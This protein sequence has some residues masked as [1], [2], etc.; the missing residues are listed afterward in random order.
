MKQEKQEKNKTKKRYKR[1]LIL[2]LYFGWELVLRKVSNLKQHIVG[3]FKEYWQYISVVF[4]LI[5]IVS[6]GLIINK[7]YTAFG[8]TYGWVQSTWSGGA[9]TI[10]VATHTDNQSNWTKYYSADDNISTSS[11]Q[12]TL[13]S[14]S[15][16]VEDTE[17]T[18]FDGGTWN[19]DTNSAS[20]I[21]SN[22]SGDQMTGSNACYD[23]SS[24]S[25]S[26]GDFLILPTDMSGTANWATAMSYC[27]NLCPTCE[28]P[29]STEL[30]CMCTNKT[31]FGN[32]F[33]ASTYWSATELNSAGAYFVNFSDC[34]STYLVKASANFVRCVR[35]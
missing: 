25:P 32:N 17:T 22:T 10:A 21:T 34:S 16:E 8:A 20:C 14:G 35:R 23:A 27:E 28:L 11:D 13:S 19:T 18:D 31:S 5:I 4:L 24:V 1:E 29:N 2:P 15:S 26:C 3:P 12:L 6:T 30:V 9:S 7:N 33:I